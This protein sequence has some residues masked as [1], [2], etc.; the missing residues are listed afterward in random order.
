LVEEASAS[1]RALEQQAEQLVQTVA[2]FRLAQQAQ[3]AGPTVAKA[4]AAPARKV[5]AAL[6]AHVSHPS[7]HNP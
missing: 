7:R 3:A 5:S 1:A 6:A 2:V 4:K